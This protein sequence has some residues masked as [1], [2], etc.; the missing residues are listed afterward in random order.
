M[1]NDYINVG[2]FSTSINLNALTISG[3][4]YLNTTDRSSS[5]QHEIAIGAVCGAERNV[6]LQNCTVSV[7]VGDYSTTDYSIG[8]LFGT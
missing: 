4:L 2:T 1:Y 5:D 6:V 8:S 3:S 7:S